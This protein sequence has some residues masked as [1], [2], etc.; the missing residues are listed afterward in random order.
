MILQILSQCLAFLKLQPRL[1]CV[2]L[3]VCVSACVC[4]CYLQL[5]PRVRQVV[6]LAVEVGGQLG[7]APLQGLGSA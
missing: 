2:S 3:H 7:G 6:Y 1:A 4:V 5:S